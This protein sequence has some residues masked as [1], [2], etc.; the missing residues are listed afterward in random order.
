V[1]RTSYIGP[2]TQIRD[3]G[4]PDIP[5]LPDTRRATTTASPQAPTPAPTPP[6]TCRRITAKKPAKN[7]N[8]HH[9]RR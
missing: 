8:T 2:T 9:S 1:A 5:V 4:F 3:E 7:Q 6:V